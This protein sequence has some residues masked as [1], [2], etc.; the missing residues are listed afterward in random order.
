MRAIASVESYARHSPTRAPSQSA[1]LSP[2]RPFR[3]CSNSSQHHRPFLAPVHILDFNYTDLD[4]NTRTLHRIADNPPTRNA[5]S[6]SVL[7]HSR[8]LAQAPRTVAAVRLL[9]TPPA[10]AEVRTTTPTPTVPPPNFNNPPASASAGS[11]VQPSKN[12]DSKPSSS[13]SSSSRPRRTIKSKKAA[14]TMVSML[15]GQSCDRD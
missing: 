7:R 9:S 15:S 10:R 2:P 14:L 5:M 1:S 4:Y 12:I 3:H 6:F 13:S 8:L 11:S